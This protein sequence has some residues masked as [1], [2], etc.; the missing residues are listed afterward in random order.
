MEVASLEKQLFLF[1]ATMTLRAQEVPG[2]GG[3]W[4]LDAH[5]GSRDPTGWAL[6]RH[7]YPN[8]S[9]L[10]CPLH[11]VPRDQWHGDGTVCSTAE[12]RG[13][14]QI[15]RL[16]PARRGRGTRAAGRCGAGAAAR[17]RGL[18]LARCPRGDLRAAGRHTL[19][20]GSQSGAEL[21]PRPGRHAGAAWGARPGHTS[22]ASPLRV[23]RTALQLSF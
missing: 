2:E 3:P 17:R 4:A 14:G 15:R 23:Q 5:L 13:C 10:C 1:S 9:C 8:H 7:L 11:Q 16:C 22:N 21:R 19:I 12:S 18:S 20:D 6:P